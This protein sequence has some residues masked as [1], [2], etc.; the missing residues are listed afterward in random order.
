MPADVLLG[1]QLEDK[2]T[3]DFFLGQLPPGCHFILNSAQLG[4][5]EKVPQ[6]S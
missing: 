5:L 4:A 3:P 1:L 2:D 6:M